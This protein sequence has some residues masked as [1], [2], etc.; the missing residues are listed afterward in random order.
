MLPPGRGVRSWRGRDMRGSNRLLVGRYALRAPLGQGGMGVVWR[1]T[2]TVL[3]RAVAIKEVRLPPEVPDRQRADTQQ[4][5]LREARAAARLNHPGAVTVHD[6]VQDGGEIFI[7][8]ELV[9]APNLEQVVSGQGPL[10]AERAARLGLELLSTLEAAH[11][12]GI[13]HRDVKPSNILLPPDGQAKLSDFGIAQL[14][15]DP[16]LTASGTVL[17]SPAYM[18]PEQAAGK[19]GPAADR[20]SLGAS[21]YFA[22]TGRPP[23]RG[24]SVMA[25]L[26]AVAL[27]EPEPPACDP[28]LS[29][30]IM[31]LLAKAPD[32][33]PGGPGL[34]EQF[35]RVTQPDRSRTV[36]LHPTTADR[37]GAAPGTAAPPATGRTAPGTGPAGE[38]TA[39]LPVPAARRRRTSLVAAA[40]VAVAVAVVAVVAF[41][42]GQG[43]TG[44]GQRRPP[45]TTRAT[46]AAP[47]ATGAGTATTA[48]TT[49]TTSPAATPTSAAAAGL[50]QTVRDG[51]LEFEVRAESCRRQ[52]SGALCTVALRVRNLERA[53]RIY[54]AASQVL[55]DSAGGRHRPSFA[56]AEA[57]GLPNADGTYLAGGASA[58]AGLA[59]ELPDGRRA[60]R[61]ELHGAST[62]R[63]ATVPL[64]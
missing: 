49:A 29:S 48:S 15:G 44:A 31:A 50:P 54:P 39:G 22:V 6:V 18:A 42:L 28:R 52:G 46:A 60:V 36:P 23:F 38:P 8:M 62:G 43:H 30:A 40:A 12:A 27:S 35:R 1:A 3:G 63:G 45:A 58:D 16:Q 4:R 2:D 14:Q 13:V 57:A 37:P 25:T 9:E 64:R 56:R 55:V 24:D 11:R 53:G 33:R 17:G 59:F 34:L 21:L 7:V 19:A 26:A 51:G 61:L 41:I 32:D 5:I 47:A 10:A 20:W